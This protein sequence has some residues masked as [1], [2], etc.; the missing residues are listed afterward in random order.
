LPASNPSPW[1]NSYIE[2]R[3][4]RWENDGSRR[5]KKPKAAPPLRRGPRVRRALSHV[6]GPTLVRGGSP[7]EK[8]ALEAALDVSPDEASTL[9]HVH[10]FHSYPARLHPDTARLLVTGFSRPSAVVLDPF[11]GSGTVLVEARLSG[12]RALGVDVNPLALELS[13]LKANGPDAPWAP[14]LFAAA[15]EVAKHADERRRAKAGATHR[16]GEEDVTL[17]A[18]HV[19]LELD[20]LRAGIATLKNEPL[21]RALL[22]VLSAVL[23]KVSLRAGDTGRREEPKRLSSGYT[24]RFFL[25][26]AEDLVRRLEEARE[27]LPAR[28][29]TATL[30]H[31]DARE[32]ADVKRATVDLVV[33]SPPYPGVYDYVIHH[34]D[35]LRW[36][37]FD[38]RRFEAF[39]IGAR[40]HARHVSYRPALLR[41]KSEMGRSLDQMKRVLVR[42][43]SALIVVADSVLANQPVR[44]DD[45]LY[46]LAKETG[47]APVA[48]ASQVRPHFHAPTQRAF[49]DAPRREHVVLLRNE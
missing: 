30:M 38:A 43:G 29:P 14:R 11:C 39:E 9:G 32:L 35:R 2:I 44:A 34:Q 7:R 13:L 42:G 46:E 31:G 40:R 18:P 16:Y 48:V 27:F 5:L 15:D 37:G 12:R 45:L 47:L 4:I 17:F 28:A 33:T 26:R 10:G 23:T 19:L 6:G 20:G 3:R 21:E 1:P 25:K 49:R 41:F 22:L 36:L 24:I 8:E